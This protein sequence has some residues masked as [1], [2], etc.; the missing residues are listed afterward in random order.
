MELKNVT[1][2]TDGAC[3]CNP[4]PGGYAAILR[5]TKKDGTDAVREIAGFEA[6]TT[7]NK[8]E[9]SAVIEAIKKLTLPCFIK[10]RTDSMVVCNAIAELDKAHD[11]GW[12]TKSGGR[13]ANVELLQQLYDLKKGSMLIGKD[14]NRLGEHVLTY[15]HVKGHSGDTDNERCDELAKQQIAIHVA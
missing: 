12:K 10:V 13:R 3:S 7:N 8:M 14:G 4:G 6:R 11:N 2:S 5:F 1:I 15:E 9:L